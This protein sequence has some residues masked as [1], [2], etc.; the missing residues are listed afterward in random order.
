MFKGTDMLEIQVEKRQSVVALSN[1]TGF[2]TPASMLQKVIYV[3]KFLD[4]VG[5]AGKTCSNV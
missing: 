3:C 1:K 5:F 4:N 2:I